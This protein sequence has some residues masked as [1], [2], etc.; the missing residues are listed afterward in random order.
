MKKT[1]FLV[2]LSIF[3]IES[4][5]EASTNG[6]HYVGHA[7]LIGLND[8]IYLQFTKPILVDTLLRDSKGYYYTN[9]NIVHMPKGIFS[10]FHSNKKNKRKKSYHCYCLVCKPITFF[11]NQC[12]FVKHMDQKTHFSL[13]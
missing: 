12:R 2:L 4:I 9:S 10:F 3:S 13:R 11:T 5:I 7:T 8:G 6:R 1:F